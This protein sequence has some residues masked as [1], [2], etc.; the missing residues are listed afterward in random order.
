MENLEVVQADCF[1]FVQST[2]KK[3][4]IIFADPPY[5]MPDY[6]RLV[7]IIFEKQLLNPDGMLIVEHSKNTKLG[8]LPNYDNTRNY[9]SVHFSFFEAGE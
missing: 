5:D 3:Y 6:E 8:H 1:G 2:W 9:G 7:N 4:D